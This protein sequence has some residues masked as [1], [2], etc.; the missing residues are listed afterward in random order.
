M[1]DYGHSHVWLFAVLA[2][3]LETTACFYEKATLGRAVGIGVLVGLAVLT[4]PTEAIVALVPL[5]F[6][7]D[8]WSKKA[9][10]ERFGFFKTNFRLIAAA[11]LAAAAVGSIQ[12]FY[13]K[14]VTG[15]WFFYSYQNETFSFSKPHF[16]DGLFSARKGWLVWTPLMALALAGFWPFF[17]RKRALFGLLALHT[18]LNLWI[19]FAWDCWWYGGSI[20]QRAMVQSYAMLALPLAAFVEWASE[21]DWRRLVFVPTAAFLVFLNLFLIYQGPLVGLGLDCD[22]T[23]P[24]FFRRMFLNFRPTRDDLKMLDSKDDFGDRARRDRRMLGEF[25]F[26]KKPDSSAVWRGAFDEKKGALVIDG[27][28]EFV[29]IGTFFPP[30]EA[31]W[32]RFSGF[33]EAE[34]YDW[35]SGRTPRLVLFGQTASGEKRRYLEYRPMRIL[36]PNTRREIKF[37]LRLKRKGIEKVVVYFWQPT[38]D[39]KPL[40]L[41]EARIEAFSAED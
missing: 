33:F 3:L 25:D 27:S 34:N 5:F 28:S 24:A 14:T 6:G 30:K 15:D 12:L 35:D 4:R 10:A 39:G 26:S 29:P 16:I 13:W 40:W 22:A 2:V 20:G 7:L 21:R 37:D 8:F 9:R 11:V 31:E 17:R 18:A 23:T 36:E 1:I 32:L 38:R 41:R 19:T